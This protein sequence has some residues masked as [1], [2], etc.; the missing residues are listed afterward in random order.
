MDWEPILVDNGTEGLPKRKMSST[1]PV[2]RPEK[3][4]KAADPSDAE[5]RDSQSAN[6]VL[7]DDVQQQGTKGKIAL[8]LQLDSFE[9]GEELG[10]GLF[11]TSYV[12]RHRQSSSTYVIKKYTKHTSTKKLVRRQIELRSNLCHPNIIMFHGWF[13]DNRSF[14]LVFDHA[15]AGDLYSKMEQE[16]FTEPRAANYVKQTAEALQYLHEKQIMHRNVK[17]ENLFLKSD[18]TIALDG[19]IHSIRAPNNRRS[20]ICGTLDYL[21]PEMLR[22][23]IDKEPYSNAVDRWTL[24]ILAYELLVGSAPFE[25]YPVNTQRR[26][27][28][29]DMT[30]LPST[31]SL[32]AQDLVHGVR[33]EIPNHCY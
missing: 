11:A 27:R 25:D 16:R 28:D 21:P 18:G 8:K 14:Y 22:R 30:P 1:D 6:P 13:E 15:E 29:F 10:E 32:E 2:E 20:S 9:L 12:A 7:V 33:L 4:C 23:D 5:A 26:I 24:G 3:R 17:P 19:F 31:V